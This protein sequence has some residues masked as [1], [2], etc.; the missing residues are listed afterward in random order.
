MLRKRSASNKKRRRGNN[1]GA[2]RAWLNPGRVPAIAFAAQAQFPLHTLRRGGLFRWK[3]GRWA[4][5]FAGRA[6][7]SL[8]IAPA[9]KSARRFSSTSPSPLYFPALEFSVNAVTMLGYTVHCIASRALAH[10]GQTV[11]SIPHEPALGSCPKPRGKR[12]RHPT[13][14]CAAESSCP[15][16]LD[17]LAAHNVPR[18]A[19]TTST[20]SLRLGYVPVE[21]YSREGLLAARTDV[22]ALCAT[23]NFALAGQKPTPSTERVFSDAALPTPSALGIDVS[24][25]VE[26]VLLKGLSSLAK[27]RYSDVE[28]LESALDAALRGAA[29]PQSHRRSA[30]INAS[31]SR[32]NAGSGCCGWA[33]SPAS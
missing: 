19:Q 20:P 23:L 13:R 17:S 6:G 8:D 2:F 15:V 29:L 28:T 12:W 18:D 9:E 25:T 1:G 26:S 4:A 21:Q 11:R 30:A 10:T 27:D 22:Y 14:S 5:D 3:M 31:P 24:P 32:Q 33:S 16:L 7:N